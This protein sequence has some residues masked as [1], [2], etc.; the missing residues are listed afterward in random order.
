MSTVGRLA[1]A[2]LLDLL[3]VVALLIVGVMAH[4]LSVLAAGVDYL[5]DGAAIAL[6]LFA[7]RLTR[8]ED[9]ERPNRYPSPLLAALVNAGWLLILNVGIVVAAA[10]RLASGATNVH[11]APVL[12]V[13]AVAAVVMLIATLIV[14]ADVDDGNGREDL[15]LKAVRLDIA[16]DA[17][18]AAGVAVS[19]AVI[20]VTRSWDWL[21]PAVALTIA[22]V[23]GYHAVNL[24]ARVLIAL[25]TPSALSGKAAGS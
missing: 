11:G 6:S 16:A 4:S 25:R 5:A 2:L 13:G 1:L 19:G 12:I 21:D 20:L 10:Q 23:V 18:A 14:G 17:A 24:I 15:N 22:A 9:R 8:R 7:I 3:L